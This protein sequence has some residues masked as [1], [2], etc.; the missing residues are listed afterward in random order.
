MCGVICGFNGHLSPME[1]KPKRK[2]GVLDE[3]IGVYIYKGCFS[4]FT[5]AMPDKIYLYLLSSEILNSPKCNF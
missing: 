3:E 1:K 2:L 5:P 4:N